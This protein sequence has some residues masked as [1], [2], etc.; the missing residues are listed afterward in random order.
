MNNKLITL[1]NQLSGEADWVG[2]RSH[3][4]TSTSRYARNGRAERNNTSLERGAMVEVLLAGQFAYSATS[5]LSPAGIQQCYDRAIK[6]ARIAGSYSLHQFDESARPP[7]NGEFQSNAVQSL[8]TLSAAET[9]ATLMDITRQLKIDDKI[10]ETQAY[11]LM[12]QLTVEFASSNGADWHQNFSFVTRDFS[13]TAHGNGDYQKRSL[14]ME[15]RQW[16]AE[17]LDIDG[18]AE[19]IDRVARQSLELL[20][21]DEC[22]TG[23]YDTLLMPDQL[24]LQVHESIGHPLELDRILGDER[25]YAGWSFISPAD[26]GT[27]KYGSD[28]LNVSFDPGVVGEMA[29]CKFDDAGVPAS[30]QYLIKDGML[31]RGI[32]GIE[33]QQ[34]S[35]LPGVS[36]SRASSWN[37]PPM[38]RMGNI[39]IEP[40]Q[41]SY[42]DMITSM[43][44]GIIMHT[45][46]SW[47]IDDYRNKFQ[48][49]CEYAELVENGKVSKT[50][51]NPNYRGIT[52]PFWNKL[53]MVGNA[54]SRRIWGSP[55]CGKGEPNQV[56]RV[57]HAI[58][59]C[60]FDNLDVFGGA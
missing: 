42:N 57:G 24:Y 44:R 37:R 53:S 9:Q 51:K 39:N 18:L 15:G 60:L 17:A 36:C 54:D 38:D 58:P 22:P 46:R 19:D 56:I 50:L 40:G 27:L 41:S 4:E 13:A 23:Q 8:D 5:D 20:D 32:G 47:S 25:N 26:F 16:G 31:V 49:G 3:T 10:I 2:I 33:S 48:F 14:G 29:S 1:I 12:T 21:A 55:Y 35:G 45:N 43:D 7:A 6:L 30:K 28:I 52:T 59:A 11:A 34:R